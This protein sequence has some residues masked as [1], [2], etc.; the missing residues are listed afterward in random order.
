MFS[1]AVAEPP[2]LA[3]EQLFLFVE[4]TVHE[5][6]VARNL[7]PW[8]SQCGDHGIVI[9]TI[10]QSIA[11]IDQRY[12]RAARD[13]ICAAST[14]QV[15]IP[16]LAEPTSGGY[17]SELLGE[18]PVANVSSST[19][20][21]TLSAGHQKAGPAPWLRQI[22]R[23]RAI[24]IY[25][26]LPPA[27]VLRQ[28]GSRITGSLTTS[29]CVGD[30]GGRRS[31]RPALIVPSDDDIEAVSAKR[32]SVGFRVPFHAKSSSND[33]VM[34]Q[35]C[36]SSDAGVCGRPPTR[37]QPRVNVSEEADQQ[38][39]FPR[40]AYGSLL[41]ALGLLLRSPLVHSSRPATFPNR[42]GR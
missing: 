13:S 30:L 1:P 19:G 21:H 39:V 32:L 42:S 24:L 17:L 26:D 6:S 33:R 15:F 35:Y 3:F 4:L 31:L 28:D 38:R 41:S 10:W 36:S 25:R 18:E 37:S 14:A 9:A 22:G 27:I 34:Y 7:A 20:R 2:T 40:L 23:G 12:G 11:Q 29:G 5:S 8:L 16:P